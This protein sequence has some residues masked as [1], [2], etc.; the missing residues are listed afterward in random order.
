MPHIHYRK[1]VK[2]IL[3]FSRCFVLFRELILI[4]VF[5]SIFTSINFL[6]IVYVFNNY[7]Y[8]PPVDPCPS[9]DYQSSFPGP[10]TLPGSEPG[11]SRR[12]SQSAVYGAH[13]ERC[14]Q[15]Y[16]ETQ[17]MPRKKQQLVIT[18]CGPC[19]L[20]NNKYKKS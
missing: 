13:L 9:E 17:V 16:P 8:R 11:G 6:C 15:L 18:V 20:I 10:A 5:K 12:P 4:L 3:K 7:L 19:A 1:K 2:D 14:T